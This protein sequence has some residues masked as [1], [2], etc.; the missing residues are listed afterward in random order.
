[1]STDIARTIEAAARPPSDE[2]AAHRELVAFS[3]DIEG[4]IYDPDGLDDASRSSIEKALRLLERG[5]RSQSWLTTPNVRHGWLSDRPLNRDGFIPA[6][7]HTTFRHL[8]WKPLGGLWT[9]PLL[10]SRQTVW[11]HYLD[12]R[13]ERPDRTRVI[14][15]D[16]DAEGTRVLIVTG[17]SDLDRWRADD[18]TVAWGEIHEQFDVVSFTWSAAIEATCLALLGEPTGLTGL[19]VPSALWLGPWR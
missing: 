13:G 15:V 16:V 8:P 3:I 2:A 10:N 18:L 5:R 17:K 9:S 12:S 4:R 19:S 7:Q 1:M 14:P 11:G 6:L